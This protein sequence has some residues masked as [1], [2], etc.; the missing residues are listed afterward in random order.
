MVQAEAEQAC[1]RLGTRACLRLET[2]VA[3]RSRD[4]AGGITEP[5]KADEGGVE[6]ANRDRSAGHDDR[7]AVLDGLL[8]RERKRLERGAEGALRQWPLR[9]ERSDGVGEQ[10]RLD[11]A[12]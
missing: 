7:I 9:L 8:A 2:G 4:R 6:L 12:S 11:D 1:D 3:E 10:A 5:E